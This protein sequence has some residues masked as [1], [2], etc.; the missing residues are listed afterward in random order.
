MK[1]LRYISI[2]WLWVLL[3]I[4]IALFVPLFF[5]APGLRFE[6]D[7]VLLGALSTDFVFRWHP[8]LL[9][10]ANFLHFN[11]LHIGFNAFSMINLG[12]ITKE[13]YSN[14]I[15]LIV[16][17]LAGLGGS[18]LT[19]VASNILNEPMISIGAS[20]SIFGIAGM[21]VGGT[22]KKQRYGFGLPFNFS[23]L[24]FP[25]AV[26]FFI[27]FVPGLGV[28]NWAHLGGFLVGI[29]LGLFLKHEMGEVKTKGYKN[30]ERFLYFSS[31]AIL[32]VSFF[33]LLL[34]LAVNIFIN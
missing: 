17:I 7:F 9:I 21:L 13:F 2:D 16:Y 23:E 25:I 24:I 19:V 5:I 28:N 3:G 33:L 20:G 12:R 34:N 26:A 27:G 30:F 14:R 8:W 4:N 18:I 31:F 29:V 11:F 6:S 15:I 32:I 1:R 22:L 10:T